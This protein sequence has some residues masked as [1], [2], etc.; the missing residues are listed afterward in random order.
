[1]N[2]MSL[3][4]SGAI[5]ILVVAGLGIWFATSPANAPTELLTS[6]AAV[7]LENTPMPLGTP[8]STAPVIETPASFQPQTFTATK[9]AH[10]VSSEPANNAVLLTAPQHVKINFNFDLAAPSKITVTRNGADVTAGPTTIGADKLSMNVP[11]N[12]QQTGN[13]QVNYTACWPDQS[14]H[15]GLFGFS[16]QL[17][18]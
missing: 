15:N 12:A 18:P 13:Y 14:C 9:A 10:F 11:I 4:V 8:L 7:T 6:P 2:K 17:T 3:L 5:G 16:V 1:M